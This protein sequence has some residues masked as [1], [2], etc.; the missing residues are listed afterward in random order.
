MFNDLTGATNE[1][2]S[3]VD[4]IFAETDK[5]AAANNGSQIE[6]R[7]AGLSATTSYPGQNVTPG[8]EMSYDDEEAGES[9]HKGKI[10]KIAIFAAI[11]AIVILGGYLAYSKF[12]APQGEGN[13]V[14]VN[15]PIENEVTPVAEKKDD[16]FI[17]PSTNK[18][19][20]PTSTEEEI[21]DEKEPLGPLDTD[22]DGLS[23][24][25]E[26]AL[27]T[28]QALIDSDGDALNDFDEA[29]NH[30]TDPLKADT[31]GDGLSDYEEINN[32]GTNPL[33]ADTDGDG[34]NDADEIK[35]G[36]N[37]R[38]DGKLPGTSQ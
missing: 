2:A 33:S 37:P 36:Y 4:D 19:T 26:I 3:K 9:G 13:D 20:T 18:D 14:P 32:W 34:Y 29:K 24:V 21:P 12:L 27:G 25:E 11:G 1:S 23:D 7:P 30:K 8:A 16:G 28:N 22:G 15:P 17:T 6:T 5:T 31:D 10:L 38:G 35:A